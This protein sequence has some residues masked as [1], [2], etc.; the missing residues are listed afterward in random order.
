MRRFSLNASDVGLRH[1]HVSSAAR[2]YKTINIARITSCSFGPRGVEYYRFLSRLQPTA[3]TRGYSWQYLCHGHLKFAA[4]RSVGDLPDYP[5]ISYAETRVFC[6]WLS[7]RHFHGRNSAASRRLLV[8]ISFF[9]RFLNS[10][11][12]SFLPTIFLFETDNARPDIC[13]TGYFIKL[14][15]RA[16]CGDRLCFKFNP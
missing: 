11:P 12:F 9:F 1:W 16:A 6:R 3:R 4:R 2:Y 7:S 13:G 10:R 8:G 15:S 14:L 5:L